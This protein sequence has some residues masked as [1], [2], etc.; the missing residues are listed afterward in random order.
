M[1]LVDHQIRQAVADKELGIKNFDDDSV[2][3]ATYDLRIGARVYAGSE[4][5][6]DRPIDL[7]KNGGTYRIPPYGQVILTTYETLKIPP[8]IAGRFGLISSL[9]RKGLFASTGPQV[10]PG[11]E[12]K[13][14]VSLLNLMPVG[15]VISYLEKFLSI[16]FHTLDKEPEKTYQG[17]HQGQTDVDAETLRDLGRLE[18]FNLSQMQSQFTELSQHM[19][20]WSSLATRF[21]EFLE[22][23]TR[24]TEAM[25]KLAKQIPKQASAARD[26][27]PVETRQIKPGQA[28]KEILALFKQRKRLYYSDIAETLRLDFATVVETCQKLERQGLIEGEPNGKARTKASRK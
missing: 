23:M 2:Q 19:R 18:G 8:N 16:E 22:K 25:E 1:I 3:P 5:K 26:Y 13:L 17:P 28:R 7:T 24:Q 6:P 27:T 21:D 20:E 11:Y 12:G 4:E 15:H 9:T 10:D 14:I